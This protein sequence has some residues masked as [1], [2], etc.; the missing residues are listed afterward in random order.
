[1]A[2][3]QSEAFSR[4]L[5]DKALEFSG[6]DLLDSKQV[7][8]ELHTGSGRADYLMKDKL[9][10]VLFVLE[11]TREELDPYDAKEQARGYVEWVGALVLELRAY[12]I[13]QDDRLVSE[14]GPGE[15]LFRRQSMRLRQSDHDSLLPKLH[16]PA[17]EARRLTSDDGD[18]DYS[19]S[20]RRSHWTLTCLDPTPIRSAI[21][22]PTIGAASR[23]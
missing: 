16:A 17:I 7:V 10:R 14:V 13:A 20:V 15:R 19:K 23:L 2:T 9:G 3:G 1:M 4:I 6:W 21:L 5:I 12:T 11:A 8:F 18:A 22:N